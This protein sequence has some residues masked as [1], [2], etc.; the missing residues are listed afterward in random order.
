MCRDTET[1]RRK[2]VYTFGNFVLLDFSLRTLGQPI[3]FTT[4]QV[5]DF[6]IDIDP[7][8]NRGC[9]APRVLLAYPERIF[10]ETACG[11]SI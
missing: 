10:V 2:C 5:F 9:C 1:T 4:W 11:T 7:D 8:L 3:D 6:S